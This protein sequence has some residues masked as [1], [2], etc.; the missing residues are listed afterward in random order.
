MF[1]CPSCEEKCI[2]FW[3]KACADRMF[4]IKCTKCGAALFKPVV[5]QFKYIMY[6]SPIWIGTTLLAIELRQVW[7]YF[8][9]LIPMVWGGWKSVKE[10]KLYVKK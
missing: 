2:S 1:D 9:G 3:Q 10:A 5:G 4:P 6:S 7:I 8:L